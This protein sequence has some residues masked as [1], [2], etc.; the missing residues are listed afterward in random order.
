MTPFSPER[1]ARTQKLRRGF[2]LVEMM[3]AMAITM[4]LVLALTQMFDIVGERLS[5]SRAALELSGKMRSVESRLQQDL[6]GVTVPVRPW[7]SNSHGEG[8]FE[9][10]EGA[11]RDSM[12]TSNATEPMLGDWDDRLLFTAHSGDKPFQGQFHL[13][14]SNVVAYQNADVGFRFNFP[15][16][17]TNGDDDGDGVSDLNDPKEIG[18]FESEPHVIEAQNAEIVWWATLEDVDNDGIADVG[19]DFTIRRRVL[20]IRPDLNE[21]VTGF[22]VDPG[23]R[24]NSLRRTLLCWQGRPNLLVAV[25]ALRRLLNHFDISL[26]LHYWISPEGTLYWGFRANSLADLTRREYRYS[27]FGMA[28]LSRAINGGLAIAR[29]EFPHRS[30]DVQIPAPFDGGVAGSVSPYGLMFRKEQFRTF[31]NNSLISDERGQ[32]VMLPDALAFD[33]RI[34]DSRAALMEFNDTVLQPGDPGY[35]PLPGTNQIRVGYGAYVDLYYAWNYPYN[36]LSMWPYFNN[37]NF[38]GVWPYFNNLTDVQTTQLSLFSGPPAIRSGL[39]G[40]APTVGVIRPELGYIAPTSVYDTWSFHYEH[41]QINNDPGD[42]S[43][44]DEGTDGLIADSPVERETSPP[45]PYPVRGIQ[46]SLRAINRANQ[47][48]RQASII[49]DFT[50]E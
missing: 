22:L 29:Y 6:D 8:Y 41:D 43:L 17:L 34:F 13:F 9:Y 47:H 50:P 10:I 45:Y 21:V 49:S 18:F 40:V 14:E 33:V 16:G 46:V 15:R 11:W 35:N 37:V 26:R 1:A 27:R 32:D 48:V 2:T 31:N 25:A 20:L 12:G 5:H 7:S 28:D 23:T 44:I 19:E 24:A 38:G 30:D 4:L 36:Y 42:D 39:R 3:V